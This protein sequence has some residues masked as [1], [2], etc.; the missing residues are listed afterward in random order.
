VNCEFLNCLRVDILL[1]KIFGS[2]FL[3][4][5]HKQGCIFNKTVVN[6]Y[7]IA[8]LQYFFPRIIF[9]NTF[10]I[11]PKERHRGSRSTSKG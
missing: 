2:Y 1:S 8:R 10:L 11:E 6:C 3:I 5:K 9:Q 4:V 7:T